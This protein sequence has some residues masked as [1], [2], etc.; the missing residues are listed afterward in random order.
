[1]KSG[2]VPDRAV[3]VIGTARVATVPFPELVQEVR[4]VLYRYES[5]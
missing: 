3:I 1:M 4:K 5:R 2:M